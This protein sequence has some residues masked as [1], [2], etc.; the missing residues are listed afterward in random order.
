MG[1]GGDLGSGGSR[2]G[3]ISIGEDL[4]SFL[5]RIRN[6]VSSIPEYD[7]YKESFDICLLRP[8][9]IIKLEQANMGEKIERYD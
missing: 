2:S 1:I 9:E 7:E 5:E 6:D 4:E 3:K 8:E